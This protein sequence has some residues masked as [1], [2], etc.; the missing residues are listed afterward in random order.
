MNRFIIIL[1]LFLPFYI[2]A[3]DFKYQVLFEGIGDNREYFNPIAMPQTILGSRG[4]F[5]LGISNDNHSIM[6]GLSQLLEFGSDI[7]FHKPKLTLYYHYTDQKKDFLFG[8]FP[9]RGRIDFPLAML[10]DTLLYY[11]P[12]IE[13]I[14]SEIRWKWGYQNGFVDWVSRQTDVKRENFMA[15]FSG[16][17]FSNNLFLQNYVLLFH[18]AGPAIDI[19]GDHLKDYLGFA[20][21]AGIRTNPASPFQGEIKAGILNSTFRERT[22]TDG[23]LVANSFFAEANGR[24][25]NYGL[26]SVMSLGASHKFAY[27][28]RFYRAENYWR[29]DVLWYFINHEKV[30]G[31]FNL[32]FHIIDWNDL[33]QQQQLSIIYIFGK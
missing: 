5:E 7:D 16:E 2:S 20:L 22:I 12:N 21:Q 14:F 11:R 33:D 10:T 18:D 28:D 4:A 8:A 26:K 27:G 3:Q 25:G 17:I 29:T 32:S 15:G 6:A 24:Y 31:R 23:F 19:S 9:R 1:I 30:K 13:G